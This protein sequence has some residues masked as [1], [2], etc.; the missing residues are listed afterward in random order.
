MS[1]MIRPVSS[2]G[3]KRALE[4]AGWELVDEGQASWAFAKGKGR[5]VIIVPKDRR[6]L[7]PD[8]MDSISSGDGDITEAIFREH[9]RSDAEDIPVATPTSSVPP[10]PDDNSAME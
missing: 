8:I 1:P 9:A 7:S 2:N 10:P 6:E 4:D 3:M 5:R